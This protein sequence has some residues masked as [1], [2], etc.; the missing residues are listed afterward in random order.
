M[1][2]LERM[3][4]L[5]CGLQDMLDT[6]TRESERVYNLGLKDDDNVDVT[7]EDIRTMQMTASALMVYMSFEFM[8]EIRAQISISI[9]DITKIVLHENADGYE[10]TRKEHEMLYGNLNDVE[11]CI[12]KSYA[13]GMVDMVMNS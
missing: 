2:K 10:S 4:N 6:L 5:M 8:G 11:S 3:S 12:I 9:K 1:R 13:T 7:V